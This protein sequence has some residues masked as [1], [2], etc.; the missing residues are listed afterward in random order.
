V[1]EGHSI[2]EMPEQSSLLSGSL[3]PNMTFC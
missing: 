1:K 3:V 2:D